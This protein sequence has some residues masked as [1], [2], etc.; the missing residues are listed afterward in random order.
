MAINK[1]TYD[2]QVAIIQRCKELDRD[3]CEELT[4][5]GFNYD[6]LHYKYSSPVK[7]SKV[8]Y[9]SLDELT[10]PQNGIPVV[11]L[12]S[13]CGGMDLG[14]EAAGFEHVALVDNNENFCATLRANK[15]KW[16]II[17]PPVVRGDVSEREGLL[18]DLKRMASINSPFDGVMIG[19]PP[20][21]PFSIASN[22]RYTKSGN[23]FKRVGFSHDRQG[24]LLFDFIWFVGLIRPRV[25]LVENVPGLLD[26][27]G[28][29]QLNRALNALSDMG[30]WVDHTILNAADYGVPQQRRRLFII[31]S[32]QAGGFYFPPPIGVPVPCQ[33][34]FD[35]PIK[36]AN[37]HITRHHKAESIERYMMLR[38]GQRDSLGRV[39]RLDPNLPAKTVIAG[40]ELGGGRSHLH[41]HIPRTLSVRE[42]ARLQ[43][44]PDDYVFQG[45]P[46]R[47]YTQVGNAVPAVL[48]F[49]VA[50]QIR[51]A[52]F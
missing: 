14:F 21:Q 29:I 28:G 12:F 15:P 2:R 47:Q 37:N 42:C 9:T 18:T 16:N 1:L 27:D 6:D 4:A 5:L 50:E 26:I 20:C 30:Y 32:R 43:T 7:P 10:Q 19:G 39:D 8:R 40:G 41:P 33:K 44:F 34:V 3:L 45:C 24:S 22:Q 35:L 11:S 52:Y 51:Q 25:F 38:Y 13:G 49:R 31:G 36:K 17:G 23:N 48:A 46:A